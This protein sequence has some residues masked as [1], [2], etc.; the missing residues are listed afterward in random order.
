LEETNEEM[1]DYIFIKIKSVL[2][3]VIHRVYGVDVIFC[4][5]FK[6]LD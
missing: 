5:N 1:I 4:D 6:L 3:S 2:I